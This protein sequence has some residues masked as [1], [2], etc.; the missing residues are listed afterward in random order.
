[1]QTA[2]DRTPSTGPT[3][4]FY[5]VYWYAPDCVVQLAACAGAVPSTSVSGAT[6]PVTPSATTPRLRM[7]PMVG[8]SLLCD[9]RG[10]ATTFSA[11]NDLRVG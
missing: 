2:L 3:T 9:V 1:M 10:P 11:C 8:T 5:T 6:S 4:N 7:S